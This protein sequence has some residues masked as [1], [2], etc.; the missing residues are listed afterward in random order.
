MSRFSV[1]AVFKA[2]DQ[3]SGPVDKMDRSMRRFQKSLTVTQSLSKGLKSFTG[4]IESGVRSL[5]YGTVAAYGMSRGIGAIAGA[6]GRVEEAQTNFT[7]MLEGNK[8]AAKKL[9]GE[10][11]AFAARSSFGFND[12]ANAST[13]LFTSGAGNADNMVSKLEMLGDLAMG[14]PDKLERLSLVYSQIMANMK[15]DTRDLQQFGDAGIGLRAELMKDL[16]MEAGKFKEELEAGRIS[17]AMV[18][19][20]LKRLTTGTGKFAGATKNRFETLFGQW[21]AFKEKTVM[22][23]AGIGKAAEEPMK[24]FIK[25]MIKKLDTVIAWLGKPENQKKITD[26]ADKFV[27][28]LLKVV[29]FL[30]NNWETIL[31]F[32]KTFLY[33]YAAA[34][35]LSIGI[36]LVNAG[37]LVLTSPIWLAVAAFAALIGV[38]VLVGSAGDKM[39]AWIESLPFGFKLLLA[40]VWAAIKLIQGLIWVFEK[41]FE[42][43]GK[44]WD[45]FISL[46][47][48]EIAP[49]IETP[50]MKKLT[51]NN[52]MSVFYESDVP[53]MSQVPVISPQERLAT[54]V[55]ESINTS[56]TELLIKDPSGSAELKEPKKAASLGVRLT[57]AGAF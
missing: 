11:Y 30:E 22:M 23:F 14:S 31:T 28:G 3:F 38:F 6:Y 51:S 56:K 12:L 57:P 35:I 25:E 13:R 42:I 40:P 2:I 21:D 49:K 19:K 50:D 33:M 29:T 55:S 54:S 18:E 45:Q 4:G 20:T 44:G 39:T 16:G 10:L 17:S 37:L 41:L 43:L 1:D 5:T 9:T 26:W 36:A 48:D 46:F 53:Q 24:R 7:T 32:A 47:S 52:P 27:D 34:K 8:D 15:A